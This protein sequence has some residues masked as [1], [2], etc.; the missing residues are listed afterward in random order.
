M[1]ALKKLAAAALCAVI[2]AS[3][4]AAVLA[5]DKAP[6]KKDESVYLILNDNGTV[7]EQIVSV[8]LHSPDGLKNVTD[9][10]N[11]KNIQSI[12][13]DITPKISGTSVRWATADTDV[14]YKGTCTAVPPLGIKI[15]YTLNG[16][17]IAAKDLIGK[18]GNIAISISMRNNLKKLLNIDGEKR[19]VYTPLFAGLVVDMPTAVFSNVSAPNTMMMTEGTNQVIAMLAMPGLADNFKGLFDEQL[20]SIKGKISG[21]ITITAKADHF[22]FPMIMGGAAT[23]FS[24]LKNIS[25]LSDTTG[26][27]DGITKLFDAIDLLGN[28]TKTLSDG[29]ALYNSKMGEFNDGIMKAADGITQLHDGIGQLDDATTLLKDKINNE[30]IPGITEAKNTKQELSDQ[31]EA[32]QQ[33]YK[34]I[35]IPEMADVQPE[36]TSMISDVCN[37]SSDATVKA[38]T[39]KSY[40]QLTAA[41]KAKILSARAKVKLDANSKIVDFMASLNAKKIIQL[42]SK[43]QNLQTSASGMLG[44]MDTLITS[45]YN[46]KD[47]ISNPTSLATAILA[48]SAG[49]DKLDDGAGQLIDGAAQLKDG[50]AQL[51][52]GSTKLADGGLQLKNGFAEFSSKLLGTI[53]GSVNTDTVKT[54]LAVK[55]AMIEQADAYDSYTGSPENSENSLKFIIKVNEPVSTAQAETETKSTNNEAKSSIWQRLISWI[56]G[57][58]E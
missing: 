9:V 34:D 1:K 51:Y 4:P 22:E 46:P 43:L 10:S 21:E 5:A 52:A 27:I 44:G 32:V 54:A 25:G 2:A 17:A 6:V 47:D 42:I 55:D 58:F 3:S 33:L 31:L 12:K 20:N 26:L 14:Y 8:W 23:K 38:L 41:Q 11:L 15:A 57:I 13:S 40:S 16:K 28:G 39:G 48:L 36:L 18:S 37:A 24:D 53:G 29:L 7:N 35:N 45:L 19:T 49:V 50:S 56:K 30:L